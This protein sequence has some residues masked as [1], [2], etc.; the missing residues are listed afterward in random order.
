M[1]AAFEKSLAWPLCKFGASSA[2]LL[3]NKTERGNLDSLYFS[4]FLLTCSTFAVFVRA[5]LVEH[6]IRRMI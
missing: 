2:R 6:T 1:L 4:N 5:S 3:V